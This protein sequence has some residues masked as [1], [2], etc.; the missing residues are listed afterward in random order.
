MTGTPLPG[1]EAG[2]R[3]LTYR[4]HN[5]GWVTTADWPYLI[6]EGT[7]IVPRGFRCDLASI[8]RLFHVIPGFGREELGVS[9]PVLHDWS[10][11]HGGQLPEDIQLSRQRTDQLFYT[12]MRCDEVGTIRAHIA[13]AAVRAFGWLAWRRLPSRE[14]ALHLAD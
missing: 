4:V 14:W 8:P 10:Y 6:G 5:G 13:W 12:L 3:A 11:R 1:D 7:V 2:C 9:G